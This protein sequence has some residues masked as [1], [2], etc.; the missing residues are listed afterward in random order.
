MLSHRKFREMCALDEIG[1][2]SEK[3]H[4]LLMDHLRHCGDCREAAKEYRNVLFGLWPL[5]YS[6]G[7]KFSAA[8]EPIGISRR[9]E[10][11]QSFLRLAATLALCALGLLLWLANKEISALDA[12]IQAVGNENAFLK[13]QVGRP[14]HQDMPAPIRSGESFQ[15]E[16][17][18]LEG[19]VS[20]LKADNQTLKRDLGYAAAANQLANREQEQTLERLADAQSQVETRDREIASLIGRQRSL[21]V[22]L[23]ESRELGRKLS[24]QVAAL[25]QELVQRAGEQTDL[26]ALIADPTLTV[27]N[28]NTVANRSARP[29]AFARILSTATRPSRLLVFRVSDNDIGYPRQGVFEVWACRQAVSIASTDG[30]QFEASIPD[31]SIALG[32][33]SLEEPISDRW[34]LDLRASLSPTATPYLLII[35]RSLEGPPKSVLYGRIGK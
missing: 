20:K 35:E 19:T 4:A 14:Q 28:V 25:R 21:E 11:I 26:E 23:K 10:K 16:L 33:L 13:A 6:A 18:P 7:E 31:N 24:A 29:R 30:L 12:R 32:V 5:A 22:N 9:R 27:V 1:E 2:L 34:S 3:E 15:Q 8:D 17:R